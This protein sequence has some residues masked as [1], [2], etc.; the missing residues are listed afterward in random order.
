MKDSLVERLG[1]QAQ[2][3]KETSDHRSFAKAYRKMKGNRKPLK[4]FI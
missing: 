1:C 3:W 4:S 2:H